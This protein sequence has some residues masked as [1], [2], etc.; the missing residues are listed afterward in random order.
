LEADS[1]RTARCEGMLEASTLS[2]QPDVKGC[3]RNDQL[4]PSQM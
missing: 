1:G 3:W 4:K 2:T